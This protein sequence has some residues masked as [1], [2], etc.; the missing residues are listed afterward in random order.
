M[1]KR[2][3]KPLWQAG[4]VLAG[5]ALLASVAAAA[6]TADRL[7][8]SLPTIASTVAVDASAS[9]LAMANAQLGDKA[10][11]E[12]QTEAT[13]TD[14]DQTEATETDKDA[15]KDAAKD[16]DKDKDEDNDNDEVVSAPMSTPDA[17]TSSARPGWGCGDDNHDHSGPPGRPGATAPKGC[18]NAGSG[19]QNSS[20]QGNERSSHQS[21][22]GATNSTEHGKG[23]GL[24][25]D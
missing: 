1:R 19:N 18:A 24:T 4:T 3:W 22:Q 12:D 25:K 5:L 7:S 15:A 17:L 8:L 9:G 2:F 23:K 11:T 20:G 10:K 21:E 13:E 16:N 6:A 14:E